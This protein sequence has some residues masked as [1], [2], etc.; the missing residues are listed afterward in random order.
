MYVSESVH[1]P[2]FMMGPKR[3]RHETNEYA[4]ADDAAR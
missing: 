3:W 4:D 2:G 1:P